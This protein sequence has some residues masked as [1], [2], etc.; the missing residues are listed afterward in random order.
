MSFVVAND[1]KIRLFK[2]RKDFTDS[3]RGS[4]TQ[5]GDGY[6][7]SSGDSTFVERFL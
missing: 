4:N 6:E 2:L 5:D 7:D 3:F 1:K